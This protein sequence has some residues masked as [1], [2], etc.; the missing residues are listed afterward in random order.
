MSDLTLQEKIKKLC[1]EHSHELKTQD[2]LSSF[3]S[4]MMKSMVETAL[5]AEMDHHLGYEKHEAHSTSSSNCRNGSSR[6]TLKGDF[7]E[8]EIE[9]PRDRDGSFEPFSLKS[10]T[11]VLVL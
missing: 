4:L 7:G 6:K 3:S 2:D 9:T 1:K 8:I 11:L 10:D 5:Q